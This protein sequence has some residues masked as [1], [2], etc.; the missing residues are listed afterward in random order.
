[1]KLKR[2]QLHPFGGVTDRSFS[3]HD[4][5]NVI[6][7]PNEF[8]KSTLGHALWHVLFS[9]SNLTPA[10]LKKVVGRWF[11]KPSGDHIKVSLDFEADGK[12]W[13][14]QK[15]WGANATCS[16][17]ETG[18]QSVVDP[19][20]VQTRL[21]E[22]LQRNQ[23]T[24]EHVLFV[25]QA[26]LT[27]TMDALQQNASE[28]DDVQPFIVGVA[29][30]SG[31]IAAEKLE[32]LIEERVEQQFGRWDI[33]SNGP[34]KGRGIANPWSKGVGP[35]L[36]A[37]YAQE[38]VRAEFAKVIQHEKQ[39]DGVNDNIRELLV[40]LEA[41]QDFVESGRS[42]RT[43]LA[44]REGLEEKGKRLAGEVKSLK[45]V[46]V[47]WPGA[48]KVILGK[49][50]ELIAI[51]KEHETIKKELENANRQKSAEQL[52]KG[53]EK[54]VKARGVWKESSSQLTKLKRIPADSLSKLKKLDRR[55]ADLR[56]ELAAQKLNATIE[57]QESR[58]IT[59]TRGANSSEEILVD[60]GKTWDEA[61]DG[62]VKFEFEDLLIQVK[63]GNSDVNTLLDNIETAESDH[64][65]LLKDLELKD[66]AAVVAADT[67]YNDAVANEKRLKGLYDSSLQD[68]SEEDWLSEITAIN[69]LP[70]TRS[71]EVL[72]DER[73]RS[74][75]KKAELK[76]GI[77]QE[78]INVK[79]WTEKYKTLETLTDMILATTSESNEAK[80]ELEN[81]PPLPEGFDSVPEYLDR[82]DKKEKIQKEMEDK[83]DDLKLELAELSGA[84]SKQTAEELREELEFKEREFQKEK[85][86]GQALLRIQLKLE[87]VVAKREESDPMKNLEATITNFFADLTTGRYQGVRINGSAPAEVIGTHS[88]ETAI[89]SQGTAGSL[90]LATRLA[91]AELYLKELEGFLVLDDPF[92]DMDPDRR[93]AAQA[94]LGKFAE[95]HQ[96]MFFTCHPDHANEMIE[97]A[98]AARPEISG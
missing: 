18:G 46:L 98:S 48:D 21:L 23:A 19:N 93:R 25:N 92:T 94:C 71:A 40:R 70:Q 96:V 32:A 66:I 35:L 87:K 56:I 97:M 91:L 76:F 41:N 16:L 17:S 50:Q 20:T 38:T 7:G 78:Q 27:R 8:G 45:V 33:D 4:G 65:K 68:R 14:V 80:K 22:L 73:D 9:P 88:L 83:L 64:H 51:E 29:A 90:A 55:V 86:K 81:L 15:S 84:A 26:E 49:Q 44:K 60:A 67:L 54:L 12:Q 63:S 58:S 11:P 77:E 85:E 31:D 39:M 5:L 72:K 28:I 2:I 61:A 82:L 69:A 6:E 37:Y 24:W 57:S 30:I 89:L 52:T 13:T 10:K 34:E 59:V 43:G 36:S 42:L 79:K 53:Y 47:A 74:V 95:D 75:N 3:L 1:M 62:K